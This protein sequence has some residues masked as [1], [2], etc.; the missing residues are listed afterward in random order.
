[1][2]YLITG[3]AGFIGSSF[4]AKCLNDGINVINIDKLTY[5][6]NLN[7]LI[8][9]SDFSNYQFIHGD[10]CDKEIINNIF[11]NNK[12]D[13]VVN[14]AAETHVDRSI[15]NPNVFYE[16]NASGTLNLLNFVLQYWKGSFDNKLFLQIST[17]EVYGSLN[18]DNRDIKFT[19]NSQINPSSPYSASKAA[20]DLLAISYFRTYKLPVI[21]SRCSNNFGSCQFPEKLIPLV[22]E[23]AK[24]NCKIPIYGNGKNVRDWIYVDEHIRALQMIIKKGIPGEV[25]NVGG[26]NEISNI[27]LVNMILK[28][29]KK[30]ESLIEYVDDRPGHDLRYALDTEKI[31]TKIGFQSNMNFE[32]NLAETINFYLNKE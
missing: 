27:D 10:I 1:M 29:M 31:Q 16:T 30:P 15:L 7:N 23:K 26:N 24:N 19:E 6:G 11:Q 28:I 5:A 18:L 13:V 32:R 8:G 25:Y 21:V 17:D 12:I 4:V 20:A 3:G 22:I 9:I 14:F 2:T